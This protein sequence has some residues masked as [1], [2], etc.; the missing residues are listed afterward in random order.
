LLRFRRSATVA[1]AHYLHD[2]S[3]WREVEPDW[4]V[5]AEEGT[6]WLRTRSQRSAEMYPRLMVTTSREPNRACG[7][8]EGILPIRQTTP[9]MNASA[10]PRMILIT[11][12]P[13]NLFLPSSGHFDFRAGTQVAHTCFAQQA[14]T[15]VSADSKTAQNGFEG[16]ITGGGQ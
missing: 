6:L 13:F 8:G 5:I 16:M 12:P 10:N 7:A 14:R 4:F 3:P 2:G 11:R 9:I 15:G 1:G